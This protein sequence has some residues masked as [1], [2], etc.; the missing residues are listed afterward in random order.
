MRKKTIRNPSG[1]FPSFLQL[2]HGQML[3]MFLFL[4]SSVMSYAIY[5]IM[6]LKY[7]CGCFVS[8]V[9]TL[10][11][12]MGC[13]HVL[14]L[15]ARSLCRSLYILHSILIYVSIIRVVNNQPVQAFYVIQ[16]NQ[17]KYVFTTELQLKWSI[18]LSCLKNFSDTDGR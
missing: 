17:W 15:L 13:N 4:A 6:D 3:V 2:K 11:L 14:Y 12:V 1:I 7:A 8:G 10:M 9:I 16:F 5:D 18:T